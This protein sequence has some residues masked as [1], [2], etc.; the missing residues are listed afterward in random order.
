MGP[1]W[2]TAV[3][4]LHDFFTRWFAGQVPNNRTEFRSVEGA[5][6]DEFT[7][8]SPHGD[9]HDR[10]A[11]LTM[12]REAYGSG[13]GGPRISI[14]RCGVLHEHGPYALVRYFEIQDFDDG[15]RTER[16]STA[17]LEAV[18]AAPDGVRWHAVQETW[19]PEER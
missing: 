7:I 1:D 2:C 5:L 11:T 3:V 6:A 14:D 9:E 12:L 19:L 13:T 10:A 4:G 18:P 17:L 16:V 15:R 8:V